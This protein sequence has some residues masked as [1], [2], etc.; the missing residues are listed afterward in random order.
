MWGNEVYAENLYQN[1]GRIRPD[2]GLSSRIS[3]FCGAECN[4]FCISPGRDFHPARYA[5][6]KGAQI[7]TV[8]VPLN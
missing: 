6:R 4:R 1:S 7:S 3:I 8:Q 5:R 2:L